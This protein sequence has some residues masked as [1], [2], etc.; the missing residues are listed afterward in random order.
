MKKFKN[1]IFS[2]NDWAD[3]K[4]ATLELKHHPEIFQYDTEILS[5]ESKF[6]WNEFYSSLRVTRK[7][8]NSKTKKH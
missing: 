6:N 7:N 3:K 8:K 1:I 5:K 4:W 2:I